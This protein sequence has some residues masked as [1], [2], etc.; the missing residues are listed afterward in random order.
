[1]NEDKVQ[2]I[3]RMPGRMPT[4]FGLIVLLVG[5]VAGVYL[6]KV[7]NVFRLSASPDLNPKNVRVTNVTDSAFTATWTTSKLTGGF[8]KW[9]PMGGKLEKVGS[10]EVDF[11]SFTHSVSVKDLSASSEYAFEINSDGS[12]FDNNGVAW[13]VKTGPKI[14]SSPDN[15]NEPIS[16]IVLTPE[17]QPAKYALVY[18]NLSGS[19]PLSTMTTEEGRWILPISDAR[20]QDMASYLDID[21]EKT[22]IEISVQA[23]PLGIASAQVYPK[24]ARP[25]P[26]IVLGEVHDYKNAQGDSGSKEIPKSGVDKS[27]GKSASSGLNVGEVATPVKEVLLQSIEEDEV[28]TT[29]EP[30]FFG[31]GPPGTVITIQVE[32]D[33]IT[34]QVTVNSSGSWKWSPSDN[35]GDGTHKVTITWRDANGLIS[36]LERSFVVNAQEG[37]AFESTPSGTTPTPSPRFSPSPTP[38]ATLSP[39]PSPRISPTPRPTQSPLP[40][41]GTLTPTIFLLSLGIGMI[42]FSGILFFITEFKK[43]TDFDREMN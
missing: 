26:T 28:I 1:M 19:S 13:T 9:G 3:S 22:L 34:G 30:E 23:G 38:R 41:V 39:S 5:L 2:T 37:P 42:F 11:A 8:I 35:L 6:V 12:D 18:I 21:K 27:T 43:A 40:D 20:S 10:E 17:S 36:T 33:K 29:N 24:A 31:E 32:S 7:G 16:G 15:S 25:V 4:I 14:S